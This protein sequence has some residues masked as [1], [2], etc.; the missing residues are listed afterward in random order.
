MKQGINLIRFIAISSA[1]I[2]IKI[3]NSLI[4]KKRIQT[5]F[6][7]ITTIIITIDT[8]KNNI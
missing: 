7:P 2:K 4:K 8:H 5:F 6:T 3:N 1:S